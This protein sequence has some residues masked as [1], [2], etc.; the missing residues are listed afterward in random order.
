MRKSIKTQ[1]CV[2]ENAVESQHHDYAIV[3]LWGAVMVDQQRVQEN[4]NKALTTLSSPAA[5]YVR[6]LGGNSIT[7]VQDNSYIQMQS[8]FDDAMML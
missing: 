5:P 2:G 1:L 3:R 4:E 6:I 8:D 7:F